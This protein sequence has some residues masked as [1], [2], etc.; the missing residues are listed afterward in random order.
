MS[1]SKL[2]KIKSSISYL[3][4]CSR[5]SLSGIASDI[6]LV[7]G[8]TELEDADIV[9]D[10]VVLTASLASDEQATGRQ[11]FALLSVFVE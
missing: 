10:P 6:T 7:V 5:T 2:L 3:A 11:E 8:L 1:K 9:I 4:M